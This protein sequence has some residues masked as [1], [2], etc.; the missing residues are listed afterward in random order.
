MSSIW[1]FLLQTLTAAA[2]AGLLLVV[3]QLLADKLSPRWQYGIWIIL[4]VRLLVPVGTARGVLLPLPLWVETWKSIA[5]RGLGSAYADAFT[6]VRVTSPFPTV[7]GAPQSVTDWLFV[8]YVAGVAAVLLWYLASYVRLRLLLRRGGALPAA[9]AAQLEAVAERYGLRSCRAVVVPGLP[10]AF[11]CG[12]VR[13]VL[14]LPEE[15]VDDK[16]LLHELLHLHYRD[17]LQSIGWCVLRALHWCDPFLHYVFD[18]IGNDMESLC[19]QRVL[20]RLEGEERRAYGVILLSMANDRY[21]RAP[22]T[23]S[24]SNG[25]RNIARRIAAIVR[26][27]KYPRGMALVS[28][29]V[30]VAL[31]APLLVGTVAL[32]GGRDAYSVR[33][34]ELDQAMALTRLRRCTTLAG[35]LDTYAKGLRYGY[36]LYLAT[37]SPLSEQERLYTALQDGLSDAQIRTFPAGV[38]LAPDPGPL[39]LDLAQRADGSYGARLAFCAW[40]WADADG[41]PLETEQGTQAV[42]GFLFRTVRL[43]REDGAWVV[44][45]EGD[46]T[47]TVYQD[48]YDP[49]DSTYLALRY[50][51]WLDPAPL[52]AYTA[53]GE[54]GDLRIDVHTQYL[55]DDTAPQETD[56]FGFAAAS[57]DSSLRPDAAFSEARC[58]ADIRYTLTDEGRRAGATYYGMRTTALWTPDQ[59]PA[60]DPYQG[61]SPGSA[62]G[63]SDG[64]NALRDYVTDAWDGTCRDLSGGT[65]ER[66]PA[67]GLA[68]LPCGYQV[69]FLLDDRV[70]D[71]FRVGEVE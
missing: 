66:D 14:A 4:A 70:V 6:P 8:A 43:W 67:T 60:S 62:T 24:L 26:F 71:R 34:G 15:D 69:E 37:A 53:H 54:A 59:A 47:W 49:G 68:V 42:A 7:A 25:G 41:A 56:F 51:E 35:A 30:A 64:V 13:P 5:E 3:K 44:A 28:V 1:S 9:R 23:T 10:S 57:E 18:R 21:P 50:A 46:W 22:G 19:D 63:S 52:A 36:G 11:V 33:S 39:F 17:A 32:A 16:V 58:T 38:T 2:A 55:I 12:V 20:E 48:D 31:A 40:W 61:L 65:V 45:P 27:R 29:C